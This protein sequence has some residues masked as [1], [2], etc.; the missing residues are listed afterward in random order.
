MKKAILIGIIA[1]ISIQLSYSQ[2]NAK[3]II[4][5]RNL[6]NKT[7]L[8][9]SIGKGILNFQ[10][11]VMYIYGNIYATPV[12]PDSSN[13]KL[14][15][16]TEAYLYPLYNQYKKNKDEIIPGY[17]G[18]VFLILNFMGQPMQ[19]Y[20]ELATEIRPFSD[21]LTYKVEGNEHQGKLRILIKD[22]NQLDKINSI[23]PSFL[24]LVGNLS[25]ID[26]NIDSGQMPLIEVNFDEITSWKGTGNIPFEDFMKIKELV[27]KVHAQNKKISV[28][29]CPCNKT[30]AD[31]IQTSKV[32]FIN[33]SEAIRMAEFFEVTK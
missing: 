2:K 3:P 4:S 28:I 16:L 19:V 18:D 6:S 13:H 11:D 12:M 30:I 21:M 29:N 22:K 23:K 7:E 5:S 8:W 32:D 14:P 31:L 24:G 9:E 10:A 25:D 26:Q 20:K 15:T 17:I 33:T 27:T 1:C